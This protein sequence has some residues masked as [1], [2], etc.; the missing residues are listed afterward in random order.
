MMTM[1]LDG[2]EASAGP[3]ERN[4]L[5]YPFPEKPEPGNAI[6]V[7]PGIHWIRLP[8]PFQLNHINV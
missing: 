8:L 3:R 4:G 6:E 2:I 7:L 1:T 5:T